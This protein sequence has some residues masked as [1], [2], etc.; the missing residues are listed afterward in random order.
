MIP[1]PRAAEIRATLLDSITSMVLQTVI[2][3]TLWACL[4]VHAGVV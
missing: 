1:F 3:V 4:P 2:G